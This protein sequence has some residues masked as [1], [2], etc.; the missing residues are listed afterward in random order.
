MGWKLNILSMGDEEARALGV[1]PEKYKLILIT[2][3]TLT[4]AISVSAVGIV[5]WVGLMMHPRHPLLLGPDHQYLL[6]ASANGWAPSTSSS[7]TPWPAP[8]PRPRSRWASLPRF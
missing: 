5:A 6:P 1:N 7:A 3:A 8:S 2:L 4:T